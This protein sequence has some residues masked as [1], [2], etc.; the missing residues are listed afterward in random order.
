MIKKNLLKEVMK[1]IEDITKDEDTFE[2]Y[3]EQDKHKLKEFLANFTLEDNNVC[4]YVIKR[5]LS[6]KDAENKRSFS[7]YVPDPN[8]MVFGAVVN[9]KKSY[10]Q[11]TKTKKQFTETKKPFNNTKDKD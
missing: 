10:Q 3:Y 4:L 5:D 7:M 9:Y 11:F 6:L 2:K 8:Y 1:L